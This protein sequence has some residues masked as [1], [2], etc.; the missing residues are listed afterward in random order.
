MATEPLPQ[1]ADI[2]SGSP[3]RTGLFAAKSPR[4]QIAAK[5]GSKTAAAPLRLRPW[6]S[7]WRS[8]KSAPPVVY[9]EES[10][11]GYKAPLGYLKVWL[12]PTVSQHRRGREEA[13]E[14][15]LE[16]CQDAGAGTPCTNELN[17]VGIDCLSWKAAARG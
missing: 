14:R 5:F 16:T 13:A 1:V 11:D 15:C 2:T 17:R 9:T 7:N 4:R 8:P 3:L 6:R 12:R 10:Q